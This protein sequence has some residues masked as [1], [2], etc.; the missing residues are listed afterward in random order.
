V[1]YPAHKN[2]KKEREARLRRTSMYKKGEL[3]K[4]KK[5]KKEKEKK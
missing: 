2:P 5:R 4:T 1:L 3:G